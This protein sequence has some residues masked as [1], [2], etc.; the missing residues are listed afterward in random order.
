VKIL[1]QAPDAEEAV[2]LMLETALAG[3]GKTVT[4]GNTLP[5]NWKPSSTPH[6]MVALDGTPSVEY[7]ILANASVRVTVWAVNPHTAKDLVNLC[8]GL[9]LSY[10]GDSKIAAIKSLTGALVT[11]DQNTLA[12]L[13]FIAVRVTLR[14]TVL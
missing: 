11:K 8:E 7:P 12:S 13:A 3:R 2:I 6:V 14:Y 10:M 9:L 1:A 4:V 5:T